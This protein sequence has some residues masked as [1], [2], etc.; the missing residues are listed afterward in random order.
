M[1]NFDDIFMAFLFVLLTMLI[2]ILLKKARKI[3]R[4]AIK[5]QMIKPKKLRQAVHSYKPI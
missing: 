3:V 5:W 2:G 4:N 1:S